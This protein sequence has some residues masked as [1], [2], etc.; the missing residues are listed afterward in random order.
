MA[1][2]KSI[3]RTGLLRAVEF[4]DLP[5]ADVC[6]PD[7]AFLRIGYISPWHRARL[8]GSVR[9]LNDTH[10]DTDK[11]NVEEKFAAVAGYSSFVDPA[12]GSGLAII[13]SRI[14][15]RHDGRIR[16]LPLDDF[17]PEKLICQRLINNTLG[18]YAVDIRVPFVLGNPILA[19]VKLRESSRR[20][21]NAN[22]YARLVM[23]EEVLNSDEIRLCQRFCEA[24]GLDYGE[25]DILRDGREGRIYIVDVNDG[26]VGPTKALPDIDRKMAFRLIASAFRKYV[27][28]QP[29]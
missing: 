14:N 28:Q 11:V 7:V 16:R 26:P 23:P 17:D 3:R 1:L 24:I 6:R 4:D 15:A 5:D 9:V 19:Y 22:S 20:F 12:E 13:K 21:D 29:C 18:E 27:F 2:A 10:L 8:P 25:L